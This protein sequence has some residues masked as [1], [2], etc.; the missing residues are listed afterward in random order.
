MITLAEMKTH[1]QIA[2][3]TATYD[4]QLQG[5]IDAA[6]LRVEKIANIVLPRSVAETYDG[7][8]A[9]I[10]LLKIPI[11]S[12]TS[13]TE[14]SGIIPYPLT[15]AANPGAASSPYCYQVDLASGLLVRLASGGV[16]P[17]ASG[18]RNVAISYIAGQ[19]SVPAD[20]ALALKELVRHWWQ[21]GQQANRAAFSEGA[22]PDEDAASNLGYGIPRRVVELLDPLPG[23]A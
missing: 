9:T 11:L 17:F 16:I 2:Q 6:T 21:W 7:G 3:S 14:Y 10:V 19:G 8:S 1:L 12:V 15:Q 4:V 20:V 5:Y 18:V 22:V 13:V 23:I